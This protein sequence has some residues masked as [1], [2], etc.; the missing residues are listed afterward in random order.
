MQ[1]DLPKNAFHYDTETFKVSVGQGVLIQAD[2]QFKY[3]ATDGLHTCVAFALINPGAQTVLLIH[4]YN[5][6]QVKKDLS[7]MCDTFFDEISSVNKDTIC[8]VAGGRVLYQDSEDMVN[9]ILEYVKKELLTRSTSIKLRLNAPIIA[10]LAETLS[11]KIDLR[12]GNSDLSLNTAGSSRS[13][14]PTTTDASET[15]ETSS[16]DSLVF[17]PIKFIN[18]LELKRNQGPFSHGR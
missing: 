14:S 18:I 11:V 1:E 3:I 6:L 16:D 17:E 9:Y 13:S 5:L 15:S 4:F 12:S 10:D 8:V 2:E 7:K